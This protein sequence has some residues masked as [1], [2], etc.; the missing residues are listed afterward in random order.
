MVSTL[1]DAPITKLLLKKHGGLLIVVQLGPSFPAEATTTIPAFL[2]LFTAF[3]MAIK[4]ELSHT[5]SVG[6][7]QELLMMS[8][9]REVF[10]LSPFKSVGVKNH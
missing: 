6:Q 3:S 1:F 9:T 5:S 2:K 10:A 4:L 8:G 7:C